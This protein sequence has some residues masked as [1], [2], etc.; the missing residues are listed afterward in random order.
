MA[1]VDAE[2]E[3]LDGAGVALYA[4]LHPE[5]RVPAANAAQ[6]TAAVTEE[7]MVEARNPGKPARA[8]LT[9]L[10]CSTALF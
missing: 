5:R 1:L 2:G 8:R 10:M 3:D 7:P 6:A 9:I 4:A